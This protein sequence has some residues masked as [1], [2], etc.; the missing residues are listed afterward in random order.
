M[1]NRADLNAMQSIHQVLQREPQNA[2]RLSLLDFLEQRLTSRDLP[3][4]WVAAARSDVLASNPDPILDAAVSAGGIAA[5]NRRY[6]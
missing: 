6:V 3:T 1:N 5:L 2:V 4:E